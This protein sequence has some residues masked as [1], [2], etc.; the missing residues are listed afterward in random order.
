M[1][2]RFTIGH[3][4]FP[5]ASIRPRSFAVHSRRLWT[6]SVS[7]HSR[8]VQSYVSTSHDP[9]INL[10]IEHYL[11]QHSA[12]SSKVLFLYRNR[13]SIIIGR[14]Q[15]PWLEVNIPA[16]TSI[17]HGPLNHVDLVRRRSGGGTV[18]HDE[19]N[20]NWTVISP[21]NVFT[22]DK[23]VEMVVCA[24]RSRGIHRARVN[25]RHDIVIDTSTVLVDDSV[26]PSNTHRTPWTAD[27]APT[28]D[29][30]VSLKVSGSAYKLT[31]TRAL[32]HGTCLLQ[33]PNLDVIPSYL[34]SPARNYIKAK[35]V[36]SVSSPVANIGLEPKCFIDAVQHQFDTMY[37]SS[38]AQAIEIG[39]ES[40]AEPFVQNSV[41]EMHSLPW[42]F[43]QTPQFTFSSH[44]H[45]DDPRSQPHL[46]YSMPNIYLSLKHGRIV[47]ARISDVGQDVLLGRDIWSPDWSWEGVL[48]KTDV[49]GLGS[50]ETRTLASWLSTMLPKLAEL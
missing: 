12:P 31:R 47:E 29:K 4:S 18:F 49:Q 36:E 6:S 28:N 38:M 42:T 27:V 17:N 30:P 8:S 26:A 3:Y 13:P 45:G 9:Y 22:R 11:L 43:A 41:N 25:S 1:I 16:L 50:Q 7:D 39:D 23:H 24:L 33:S 15:N 40:I 14:N 46:P 21:P 20:V 48:E 34:H 44:P 10:S 2:Q 32:H 35:G 37:P 5:R 19:G